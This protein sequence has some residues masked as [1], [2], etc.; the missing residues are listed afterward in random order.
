MH[1]RCPCVAIVLGALLE[2]CAATPPRPAPPPPRTH[3]SYHAVADKHA[4]HYRMT[5]MQSIGSPLPAVHNRAPV[6]PPSL[7][8]RHLPPTTVRVLLIVNASGHVSE[9]RFA[10]VHT[11][12]PVR[13][14]FRRAVRAAVGQWRFEPLTINQ[15]VAEPDGSQRV[16]RSTP[17]PFSQD[18]VFTFRLVDGKPVVGSGVVP[19]TAR[20]AH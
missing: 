9:V 13:G 18:Y 4:R 11:N 8:A 19:A 20:D 10:P 12:D 15:W 5:A 14:A 2:A 17:K 1:Y 16:V 7:V 3:V 6:Y